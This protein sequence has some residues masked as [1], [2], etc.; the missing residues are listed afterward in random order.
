M[1]IIKFYKDTNALKL[2]VDGLEDLWTIQR[3]IFQNDLVRSETERRFRANESDVGEL[4][5]VVIKILVEKTELDKNAL[6]LRVL[7]KIVEGRPLDYIKLNS[8]HTLNIAP[9]DIIEIFKGEWPDYLIDVIKGAA[10]NSKRA[11]LG[12]IVIDDEKFLS[13]YILGYG[14]SFRNE[15]YSNLS[16]KLSPKDF[17]D[18]QNKYF[19]AA[20]DT[21]EGM[22]VDTVIIA[23][24]GF[25]KDDIKKYMS[26]PGT[27]K[28]VTK[29]IIFESVSNAEKS[30]VY[31]LIKSDKVS[32]ILEKETIRSEFMLME[33]FLSGLELKVS[34][35]GVENVSNAIGE[36]SIDTIIVNDSVLGGRDIQEL[37]D[38]AGKHRINIVI[39]NSIDE[40]GQQLHFFKD[41]AGLRA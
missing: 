6:R 10:A 27:A 9:G 36:Y 22:D 29:K 26:D 31:E 30:G 33:K 19:K 21:A 8:Y 1:K 16:K 32:S 4:K 7:G 37:L 18:Q 12:I 3:I 38:N 25:T 28:K 2:R 23:G 39:L 40:V 14:V 24:P 34:F 20:V 41:I 13:A 17:Q 11:R 5:K 15:V 35:Y